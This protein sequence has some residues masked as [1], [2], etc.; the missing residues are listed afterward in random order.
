MMHSAAQRA[1]GCRTAHTCSGTSPAPG[2]KA[3]C[4]P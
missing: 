1:A 3:L 4:W 2:T